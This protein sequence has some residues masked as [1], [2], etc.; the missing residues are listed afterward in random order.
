MMNGRR[1]FLTAVTNF[2]LANAPS[3]FSF[4]FP[5]KKIMVAYLPTQLL[6]YIVLKCLRGLNMYANRYMA[7]G[8]HFAAGVAKVIFY[9]FNFK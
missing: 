7:V 2:F 4:R 3:K 5:R 1:I 9:Y 6:V 8:R